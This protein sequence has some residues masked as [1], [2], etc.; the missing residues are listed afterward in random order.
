MGD[1]SVSRVGRCSGHSSFVTHLDWSADSNFLRTNSGDYEMLYW[2]PRT[3][4]QISQASSLR[5][6]EWASDTCT[7][8]FNT[9]GIWQEGADGTDVNGCSR[10]GENKL[11]ASGDD[12]GKVSSI[13]THV[14]NFNLKLT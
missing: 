2:N 13:L 9:C 10:N 1:G 12:F 3:C 6:V 4:K 5:D 8:S 14:T 7:L 11:L